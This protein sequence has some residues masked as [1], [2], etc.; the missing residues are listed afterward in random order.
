ME[1][2][3][4][5]LEPRAVADELRERLGASAW[6]RF[7]AASQTAGRA[8]ALPVE[9]RVALSAYTDRTLGALVNATARAMSDLAVTVPPDHAL[10]LWLIRAMDTG[11]AALPP[12]PGVY[13]R[14]QAGSGHGHADGA[15]RA[16]GG[17]PPTGAGCAILRLYLH[18]RAG[19]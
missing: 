2:L 1:G 14:G 19:R 17:R 8:L 16:L 5:Q 4:K 6:Q 7:E 11:L 13:F 9:Q 3:L 10:G 15:G 12:S 18:D